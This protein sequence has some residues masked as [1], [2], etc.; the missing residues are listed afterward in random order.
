[1]EKKWIKHHTE[2][3]VD[4]QQQPQR[5]YI[6]NNRTGAYAILL[7]LHGSDAG[8][9]KKTLI[10]KA[11][12]LC[13][14][15]AWHGIKIL[16]KK[17]YIDISGTPSMYKLTGSGLSIAKLLTQAVTFQDSLNT[18]S[19]QIPIIPSSITP[20]VFGPNTFDI[21]LVIDTREDTRGGNRI[22]AGL[23]E[24]G[25]NVIARRLELGDV[26]W[27]AQQKDS[28]CELVLDHIIERKRMDDL[29]RSIKENRFREQKAR[30]S[31]SGIRD[32]TY[33]IE[34]YDSEEVDEF[35]PQSIQTA[36]YS[37]QV[38]DGFF[39][40]RTSSIEDTIRYLAA[41]HNYIQTT[42]NNQ[43]LY[44]IPDN[45]INRTT[46]LEL[47]SSLAIPHLVTYSSYCKL[48]SK[49]KNIT[50]RDLFITMLM[51]TRGITAQKALDITR[52]YSTPSKLL[53]AYNA[54]DYDEHRK[55]MIDHVLEPNNRIGAMTSTR[56]WEAWASN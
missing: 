36:I 16:L 56:L 11:E 52:F 44:G 19:V 13:D 48:N 7:A 46:F 40:K 6:P 22:K 17:G 9:V 35:D 18:E 32:I 15:I 24:L 12:P 33:I 21:I 31:R 25:I 51:T 49:S 42:Y 5:T 3:Q 4:K 43:I 29:V 2:E 28:S 20:I 8:L 27:V 38:V 54:L 47:K 41:I 30:L 39:V 50:L 53:E 55:L 14:G 45:D 37:T 23:H 1:L 26:L 10:E 34:K